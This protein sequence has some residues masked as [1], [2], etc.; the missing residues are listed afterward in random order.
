MKKKLLILLCL[1]FILIIGASALINATNTIE[2]EIFIVFN[3]KNLY[4]KIKEHFSDEDNKI[5]H[6]TNEE[7]LT[8]R[9]FTRWYKLNNRIKP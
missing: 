1:T 8:I 7:T 5:N 4:D 9:S 6:N 2:N 3:D